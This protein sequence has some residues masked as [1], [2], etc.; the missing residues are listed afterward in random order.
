M[1]WNLFDRIINALRPSREPEQPVDTSESWP[2][3][4][5]E[6]PEAS[7]EPSPDYQETANQAQQNQWQE[8]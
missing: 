7:Q 1:S 5:N 4:S 3:G 8:D 2:E 6:P